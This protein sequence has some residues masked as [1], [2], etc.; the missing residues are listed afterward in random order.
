VANLAKAATAVALS[1]T[2]LAALVSERGQGDTDLNADGDVADGVLH[3]HP[4]GS[5]AWTNVAQEAHFLA[6]DG[7]RVAFLSSEAAQGATDLNGDGDA[8]DIVVQLY[9][10]DAAARFNIG[11]AAEELVLGSSG[12]LAF[13]TLEAR[14]GGQDLNEDGD[15]ADGVLQVFDATTGLLHASRQAVTPCRLEACDPRIPYR[16]RKDT[17]TFLTLEADQGVDLNGDGDLGDLVVQVFNVRQACHSGS[18][19]GTCKA[20]A[21]AS[22]GICTDTGVACVDDAACPGG[23]CFLPPGGCVENLGTSCD[24]VS[25]AGCLGA[26]QF[27]QPVLG[28]PNQGIC[29]TVGAACRSDDDCTGP[30]FCSRPAEDL[31]RLMDPL[32]NAEDASVVFTGAGLCTENFAIACAT[33]DD[34]ETGQFCGDGTCQRQHGVC[35]SDADCPPSSVCKSDLVRSTAIDSDGDEVPDVIDNCPQVANV[36]Q[37]DADENGVG[38]ACEA[39]VNDGDGDGVPNVLDNCPLLA[40]PGQDDLDGDGIGDACDPQTCGNDVFEG[41]EECDD[42]NT[43]SGD[44]CE[45]D[46]SLLPALIGGTK[47]L[48]REDA[49]AGER[50]LVVVSRDKTGIPHLSGAAQ[51]PTLVGA[52]LELRN[53]QTGESALVDLPAENW[54]GLGQPAGAR[55]YRY[56]DRRREAGPCSVA[57]IRP[58]RHL[59]HPERARPGK[60][61]GEPARWGQHRLAEAVREIRRH[62]RDG[63]PLGR[64]HQGP[65]PGHALLP[66]RRVRGL[67]VAGRRCEEPIF[68]ASRP[69]RGWDL[70]RRHRRCPS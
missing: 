58:I 28:S 1:D 29:H 13:R 26:P 60:P 24:P 6:I 51:D 10:A 48:L 18:V 36:L 65:V 17:V 32:G 45:S 68:R 49:V 19:A 8:D 43:V 59:V 70:D 25:Q 39:T 54:V 23:E 66:A 35:A 38:D 4:A 3:V 67:I 53:E 61:A 22:A 62:H 34:C 56:R 52:R 21:A 37:V 14:Q 12:L 57:L 44:G 27:C 42:G 64:R 16:V 41:G 40:N 9:D 69:P 46:C 5:G 2:W 11:Q 47:L 50:T 15:A 33:S 55:G 63:P 31:H 7:A 30:A 20:I